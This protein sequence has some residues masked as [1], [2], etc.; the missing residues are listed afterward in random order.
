MRLLVWL[1]HSVGIHACSLDQVMVGKSVLI[2]GAGLCGSDLHI[3]HGT[4][5]AKYPLIPGH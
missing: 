3:L 4:Y 1:N 2:L 5:P